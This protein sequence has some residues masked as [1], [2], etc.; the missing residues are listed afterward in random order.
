MNQLAL[1]KRIREERQKLQLTQ[2]QLSEKSM[3]PLHTLGL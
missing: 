3:F 1:G 2:E